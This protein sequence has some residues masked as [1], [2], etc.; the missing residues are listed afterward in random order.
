MLALTVYLSA[1]PATASPFTRP[2]AA[3]RAAH[4]PKTMS[5]VDIIIA[6]QTQPHPHNDKCDSEQ[7]E[8]LCV[9]V[10]QEIDHYKNRWPFR[11]LLPTENDQPTGPS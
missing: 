2:L 10:I 6:R 5:L 11:A 3:P 7:I 8:F 4:M 9:F 1:V